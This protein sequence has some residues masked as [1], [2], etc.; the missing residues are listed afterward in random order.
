MNFLLFSEIF[1]SEDAVLSCLS[2][3][4]KGYDILVG[5]AV[6][7]AGEPAFGIV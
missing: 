1:D 3:K 6:D 4:W 2:A 5:E 7:G